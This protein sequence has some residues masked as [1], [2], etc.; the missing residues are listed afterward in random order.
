MLGIKLVAEDRIRE[1]NHV[2]M[3]QLDRSNAW[4][5]DLEVGI[6]GQGLYVSIF[7]GTSFT[8]MHTYYLANSFIKW[9]GSGWDAFISGGKSNMWIEEPRMQK[10]RKSNVV[11]LSASSD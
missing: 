7:D 10:K 3:Y 8:L 9:L 11:I 1:Q 5:N 2:S 6:L 4:L